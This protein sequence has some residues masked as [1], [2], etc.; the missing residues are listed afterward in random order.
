MRDFKSAENLQALLDAFEKAGEEKQLQEKLTDL[1]NKSRRTSTMAGDTFTLKGKPQTKSSMKPNF[2]MVDELP[3]GTPTDLVKSKGTDAIETTARKIDDV[4]KELIPSSGKALSKIDDVAGKKGIRELA[5]KGLG[6]L[7]SMLAS[8][9][10]K[11]VTGLAG[12]LLDSEATA[13]EN[14]E[15]K[16][17]AEFLLADA[18][19]Q[20]MKG[21]PKLND[22]NTEK[23]LFSL[24]EAI[25]NFEKGGSEPPLAM[26]K[27]PSTKE[28]PK[29]EPVKVEKKQD[30]VNNPYTEKK[31]SKSTKTPMSPKQLEKVEERGS[32][33]L[34]KELDKLR[35]GREG[36]ETKD[37]WLTLAKGLL[38]AS[39][40]YSAANPYSSKNKV[41]KTEMPTDIGSKQLESR[42][43]ELMDLL[44]R[45]QAS[46]DRAEDRLFRQG[47]M[48][49][50][51]QKL[52]MSKKAAE[53]KAA[54]K[55]KKPSKGVEQLDKEFAKNYQEFRFGGGYAGVKKNLDQLTD[56]VKK[57][58]KP[59]DVTGT[60]TEK[61]LPEAVSDRIRAIGREDA[62]DIKDTVEQV[63]QQSLRQTLGAQFTEKEASRLI[64]RSYNPKL[65][66]EKNIERLNKTIEQL[67]QMAQEK[68]QAGKY[69]EEF[70]TLEGF[71]SNNAPMS[72]ANDSVLLQAPNGQTKRVKR[73]AAQKY[74]DKGARIIEE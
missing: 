22:V 18:A 73:S 35:E 40:H 15:V 6:K 43:K 41:I 36:A 10:A 28:S 39:A 60:F 2:S 20:G 49:L 65:S 68:E 64:E 53:A 44:A 33:L 61:Y 52:D 7:G 17:M 51:K 31:E 27:Q 70:G 26:E 72:S 16:S 69:F 59:G 11:A 66:D 45:T 74:I 14:Q 67:N 71:K 29:A 3:E 34:L 9:P 5:E 46:E 58:E 8:T 32:D 13:S 54:E 21:L 56:V 24:Q 57:L 25:A 62:Q 63:I 42:R 47:Q 19:K 4:G 12:A 48:D 30:I 1:A 38:D 23:D 55:S 37:A 50:S